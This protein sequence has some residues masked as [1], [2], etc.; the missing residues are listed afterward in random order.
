MRRLKRVKLPRSV[1]G[2]LDSYRATL[3]RRV[4]LERRASAPD[5][6]K[7][8]ETAWRTRRRGKA[9]AAVGVALRAMASGVE[10][11][12]YCEDSQGC[13]VEHFRPK[14][15]EPK[16]TFAWLNLLWVCAVCNRQKNDAFDP[17]I[18]D[19]TKDDPNDHLVLSLTT[20]RLVARE[21]SGRGQVTLQVMKRLGSDPALTRGRQNAVVKLHTFL[22]RYDLC[23]AQGDLVAAE[24]IRRVMV[25]EPFSA[26]LASVLRA[27]TEPGAK[28]VLGDALVEV[29]A[30]RPEVH[31]WLDGADL[32]RIE[33][34]QVTIADLAKRVRVAVAPKAR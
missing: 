19:P 25:E 1:V 14:V 5:V 34:A 3:A 7:V 16:G 8:V 15:P 9:M 11:C 33:Q 13:D 23:R 32:A 4:A 10:R 21:E 2:A 6:G 24:E 17:A 29:L 18:I 20:G 31:G 22:A 28:V 30:R 26:V 27:S 12:M